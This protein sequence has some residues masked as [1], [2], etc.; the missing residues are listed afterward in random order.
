MKTIQDNYIDINS[1]KQY[2]TYYNQTTAATIDYI[3]ISHRFKQKMLYIPP[4]DSYCKVLDSL[5]VPIMSIID[6]APNEV[7]NN[8]T[9][10]SSTT[11]TSKISVNSLNNIQIP[12]PT[13]NIP[14]LPQQQLHQQYFPIYCQ[15]NIQQLPYQLMQQQLPSQQQKY[16]PPPP[17]PP[18]PPQ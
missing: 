6:I 16:Q 18:P 13:S 8:N 11:T 4:S 1:N 3:F 14:P 7:I 5:H 9:T 12:P 2:Y 10:S 17:P 15:Q